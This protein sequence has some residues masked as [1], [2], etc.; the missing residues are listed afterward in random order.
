MSTTARIATTATIT[1]M[2]TI[3]VDVGSPEL[4]GVVGGGLLEVP[5]WITPVMKVWIE[6]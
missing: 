6:Q 1:T 5:T 3:S 2:M 4:L